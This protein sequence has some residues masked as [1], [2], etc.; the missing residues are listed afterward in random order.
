MCKQTEYEVLLQ[1]KREIDNRIHDL[2]ENT[3][4]FPDVYEEYGVGNHEW[5]PRNE[6]RVLWEEKISGE[7]G[8]LKAKSRRI[9]SKLG[10][11]KRR[12][13]WISEARR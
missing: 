1:E 9:S 12:K 10:R 11:L 4:V 3:D 6:T 7:I 13:A 2:M 8:E 5:S